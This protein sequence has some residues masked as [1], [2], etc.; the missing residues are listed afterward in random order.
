MPCTLL[1]SHPPPQ[2]SNLYLLFLFYFNVM[3]LSVL[4][5]CMLVYYVRGFGGQKRALDPLEQDLQ[6]VVR[7]QVGMGIELKSFVRTPRAL[8]H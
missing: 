7:S 6:M 2:K 8:N 4:L 3:C 1:Y 5:L